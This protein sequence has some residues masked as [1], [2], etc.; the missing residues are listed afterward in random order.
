MMLEDSK[1]KMYETLVDRARYGEKR[2]IIDGNR[3]DT[4]RV[5]T[6]LF[7]VL[8][9]LSFCS[10]V[11]GEIR[12]G[13]LVDSYCVD[14]DPF[15]S[16]KVCS[17]DN[18]RD[19]ISNSTCGRG[20]SNDLFFATMKKEV[21][22]EDGNEKFYRC[23]SPSISNEECTRLCVFG[24][25]TCSGD[26]DFCADHECDMNGVCDCKT[27]YG[28][29]VFESAEEITP[30]PCRIMV[31]ENSQNK[32]SE[33]VVRS[34]RE[35]N[36]R[37]NE[38]CYYRLNSDLKMDIDC[39]FDGHKKGVITF[40]NLAVHVEFFKSV[41]QLDVSDSCITGSS[42][43]FNIVS[44]TTRLGFFGPPTVCPAMKLAD[45]NKCEEGIRGMWCSMTW[46]QRFSFIGT[47]VGFAT[48]AFFILSCFF[49]YCVCGAYRGVGITVNAAAQLPNSKFSNGLVAGLKKSKQFVVNNFFTPVVPESKLM[50]EGRSPVLNRRSMSEEKA[51]DNPYARLL[52]IQG[53]LK[54]KVS[55]KTSLG[56]DSRE[57]NRCLDVIHSCF[58]GKIAPSD[59]I[60]E[61]ENSPSLM[62]ETSR[63]IS[64][65][66]KL[67]STGF[68][69]LVF[70]GLVL[71]AMGQ[72]GDT[73]CDQVFTLVGSNYVT[74]VNSGNKRT[75]NLGFSVSVTIPR[76]GLTACYTFQDGAGNQ[77]VGSL[78]I[79]YDKHVSRFTTATR[80]FT[81]DWKA[82]TDSTRRCY[83]A[84][85]CDDGNCANQN[86]KDKTGSG[87]LSKPSVVN[88]PGSAFCTRVNGGISSNCFY[89]NEACLYYAWGIT[90]IDSAY[91]VSDIISSDETPT[92]NFCL[93]LFGKPKSCQTISGASTSNNL[94]GG[95]SGTIVG[96]Y[97]GVSATFG[98]N[99]V[100]SKLT[101]GEAWLA[102]TANP[103]APQK[104]SIGD[105]QASSVAKLFEQKTDSFSY[106][107]DMGSCVSNGGSASCIFPSPG[108]RTLNYLNA[109]PY[110]LGT[111]RYDFASGYVFS[112]RLNPGA[113]SIGVNGPPNLQV[114]YDVI[115]GC[116]KV[117]SVNAAIG[118]ANSDKAPYFIMIAYNSCPIGNSSVSV[119][120]VVEKPM[121]YPEF[122]AFGG[123]KAVNYA[124]TR[125]IQL[126]PVQTAYNI[127]FDAAGLVPSANYRSFVSLYYN[128]VYASQSSGSQGF[129]TNIVLSSC[130]RVAPNNDTI[131]A[132]EKNNTGSG[133][134]NIDFGFGFFDTSFFAGWLGKA[135]VTIATIIGIVVI[136]VALYYIVS[137]VLFNRRR[138]A[139]M[140][141]DQSAAEAMVWSPRNETSEALRRLY[142]K[143]NKNIKMS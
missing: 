138:K 49:K 80:Y 127:S 27:H 25:E 34:K 3:K 143:Q 106:P 132:G 131:V 86:P 116:P 102:G 117:V 30:F 112:N 99:R 43:N 57:E 94:G 46:F 119:D 56:M 70:L 136:A 37:V 134:T 13:V 78:Q 77:T 2:K 55:L 28:T 61:M 24:N 130:V 118:C 39:D 71:S 115:A 74:C 122:A 9:L 133:G 29:L 6:F 68:I 16:D 21:F 137:F 107:G 19:A 85:P 18:D 93:T 91:S 100:V 103:S 96:N 79:S 52:Q 66:P 76:P 62:T 97:K 38:N 83:K 113:L 20:N 65:V 111:D 108:I 10:L 89:Y 26:S 104:N 17:Y 48:V 82:E 121:L 51:I 15:V 114:T 60:S 139:M 69:S 47:I 58:A 126:G 40:D 90:P 109:F 54:D 12:S 14:V 125:S 7:I 5:V 105:I 11:Q 45:Q 101:T 72:V 32:R 128:G 22:I 123:P 88:Q 35:E 53:I 36:V 31:K 73:S 23:L 63:A 33:E 142:G 44:E 75:C 1:W 98:P 81:A 8:A 92:V 87:Q 129:I 4:F 42:P 141:V 64:M 50:E 95:W 59:A 140:K 84:G 135:I 110:F 41:S 124:L 120:V 67:S